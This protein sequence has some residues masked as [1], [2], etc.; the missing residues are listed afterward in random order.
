MELERVVEDAGE[1]LVILERGLLFHYPN[2]KVF[3][4]VLEQVARRLLTRPTAWLAVH[5]ELK[6]IM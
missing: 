3:G 1:D 4:L 6:A 5:Q 2:R